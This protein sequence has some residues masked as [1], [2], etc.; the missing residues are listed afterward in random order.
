MAQQCVFFGRAL[1]SLPLLGQLPSAVGCQSL[2]SWGSPHWGNLAAGLNSSS[3][4]CH[5]Q[6]QFST[7]SGSPSSSTSANQESNS[8]TSSGSAGGSSSSSTTL[9]KQQEAAGAWTQQ[10]LRAVRARVFEH[11][12]GNGQRSGR[13]AILKPLKGRYIADW[14]FT[15][16]GPKMPMLLDDVEEE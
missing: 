6:R 4:S 9:A 1:H 16:T 13:K 2:C 15:L 14:Y 7:T 10:E 5:C 11:Q 8:G 12:I 3:S